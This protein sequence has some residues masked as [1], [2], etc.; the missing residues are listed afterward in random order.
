MR[1]IPE[2]WSALA[3]APARPLDDGLINDTFAVGDPPKAVV[4]R[5]HPIFR[6]EVNDDIAA[7][8]ARLRE[9]GVPT[10]MVLPTDAGGRSVLDADGRVWRALSWVPGRTIH[11]LTDPAMAREA[12]ALVGR[13]HDALAD[14]DHTFAFVRPGAHDTDLHM[15]TLRE[16]L[17]AH[18]GHRLHSDVAALADGVLEAW[19]AWDGLRDGPTT[20]THGDLKISNLR[21]DAAGGAVC[22]LDL[23]TIGRLP[24]DIEL[25]DAWRSWSN[26]NGEDTTEPAFS[27]DV[28]AASAEGY[29]AARALPTV[30]R[31]ALPRSAERICLELSA[32][33]AADALAESY[34]GW[35]E[36]VAPTRGDHNLLRARGQHALAVAFRDHRGSLERA[37]AG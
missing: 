6:A 9:R 3:G 31:E 28:L 12:G 20:I 19:A 22:L 13:W 18:R 7:V 29:L 37:L 32:R 11:R 33:F 35:S 1:R 23:D 4:Q 34:F 5:L 14:F 21:F 8:T 27:L 17:E 30:V 26:P 15:R 24:L 2:A 10:P 16:A 36:A 25:G